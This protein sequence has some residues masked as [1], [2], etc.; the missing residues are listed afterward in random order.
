MA[1]G[2]ARLNAGAAAPS[3][4][5]AAAATITAAASAAILLY[6]AATG[7]I[8][9]SPSSSSD[10][11][12]E[13]DDDR[14]GKSRR[15]NVIPSP[16]TTLGLPALTAD[17]RRALP[18]PPDGLLPGARD[19]DSPYGSIR[20]YEWG[21]EDGAKVLLVHGISTPCVALAGVAEE[22]VRRGRRVLLFDLFG[23]GLSSTPSDLPHDSRLYTTQILLALAS[24]PLA[25][26]GRR[27][28]SPSSSSTS[29]DNNNTTTTFSIVGYSLGGGIAADFAS[30]YFLHH[31]TGGGGGGL[32]VSSLVLIAPGGVLRRDRV[33]W[34]SWLLYDVLGATL[35]FSSWLLKW[36]VARRLHTPVDDDDDADD[37]DADDA[38]DAVA[39][40]ADPG[41]ATQAEAGLGKRRLKRG[42]SMA[43]HPAPLF[44]DRGPALRHVT[45]A[46]AVNWQIANHEGF[47][48]PAF[49]SSMRWAPIYGQWGRWRVV[50]ERVRAKA[51]EAAAAREREGGIGGA[52]S[53]E[54]GEEGVLLVLGRHDP[55]VTVDEVGRDAVEALGGPRNVRTVVLDAG[56]E[57]PM[58]MPREVVDAMVEFWEARDET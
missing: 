46:A 8:A 38:A 54:R 51:V 25:W 56:H 42:G 53:G 18:Y 12:E 4:P 6:L 5:Y 36:L 14:K 20:V 16:L 2:L 39:A 17:E 9:G 32:R 40:D 58:S 11:K 3:L 15:G 33:S 31:P 34:T 45:A 19:V 1:G 10:E 44:P 50:G 47:V 49:V 52:G 30:Y 21:P 23:R 24:S 13:E 29:S 35:P 28:S 57:V 37:D 27:S 7:S 26:T 48:V 43:S 55:I 41:D 22:L